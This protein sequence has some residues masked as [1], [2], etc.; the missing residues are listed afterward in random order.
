[1]PARAQS[2]AAQILRSAHHRFDAYSTHDQRCTP[3]LPLDQPKQT[4]ANRVWVSDI[5]CL[6]LASGAWVVLDRAYLCTF[7]D[8]CTKYVVGWQ[9]RPDM[10]EDLVSCAL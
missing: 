6:P 1:M 3:N 7:Q 8:V 10:S 9:V 5:T 2:V 4:Q